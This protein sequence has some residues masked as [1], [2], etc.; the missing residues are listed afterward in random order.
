MNKSHYFKLAGNRSNPCLYAIDA[1]NHA[2]A[3]IV[4]Y[5]HTDNGGSKI[6]KD[7][8]IFL[9]NLKRSPLN[10]AKTFIACFDDVDPMGR[11]EMAKFLFGILAVLREFDEKPW[12]TGK[13]ANIFDENYEFY[14]DGKV[15]FPVLM[16]RNHDSQA[17]NSLY[18]MVAF[19]P[20]SIFD[21]L[22]KNETERYCVMRKSIHQRLNIL[23]NNNLPFYL[24]D[25][26]S[27]KNIVQ[28][29]GFDPE[30]LM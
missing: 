25:K 21:F 2:R 10:K 17:R 13:T 24:S 16:C 19:Q 8:R 9:K 6:A 11:M 1:I 14:F 28:Y 7:L 29:L 20:G 22:K 23:F 26:S 27:G 5:K 3:N 30:E 18:T 4:H 15:I 12:P